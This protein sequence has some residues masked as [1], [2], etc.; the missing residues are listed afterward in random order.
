MSAEESRVQYLY[1]VCNHFDIEI[2]ASRVKRL[3]RGYRERES[4]QDYLR[5]RLMLTT[6]QKRDVIWLRA[7]SYSDPTGE[8]AV[9]NILRRTQVVITKET[10]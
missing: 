8:Q 1:Y 7:I 6:V 4:F 3:V 9:H 5:R 10:E 2:S